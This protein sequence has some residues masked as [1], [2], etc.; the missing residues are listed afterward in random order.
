MQGQQPHHGAGGP[1]RSDAV[2]ETDVDYNTR[3]PSAAAGGQLLILRDESNSLSLP[4]GTKRKM[5]S[6]KGMH[7]PGNEEIDPLLVGPGVSTSGVNVDP[8]GPAPKRRGSAFDTQKIAQLSLYDRRNSVDARLGGGSQWWTSDRR[9]SGST[10]FASTPLSGYSTPSSAF[11]GDSPHGRPP[12]GIATFAWPAN[13]HPDQAAGSPMQNE[14][15]VNMAGPAHPYDPL[16]M[17]PPVT[18]TPDRR[19][20]APTISPE[21]LPTPPSTGPTRVLRSRS[22]PPSRVRGV[23][24]SAINNAGP[25]SAASGGSAQVDDA[26]QQSQHSGKEPGS[27]PYSRSPELR[28]SH[29]LAERKRRKEMKDLFDELR[30]QLPADRG[31][32]ASKWEILSKGTLPNLRNTCDT[33]HTITLCSLSFS[34]RFHCQ[35]EA[36]SS[37]YEPRN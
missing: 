31:M 6:D 12:G 19:M 10:T 30:D 36:E 2:R 14:A 25:S 22:R 13:P 9:D 24:Q 32:K 27:T 20:S 3:R 8:E 35:F 18:F 34:H 29:K 21:N 11:P 16:A 7:S 28:I 1:Q 23:D 5:S 4:Q 33:Q 26:S 17:M 37:G 15:S